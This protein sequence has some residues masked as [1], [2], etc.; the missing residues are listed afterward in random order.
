MSLAVSRIE[1]GACEWSRIDALSPKG[2][3]VPPSGFSLPPKD[4]PA[5][6]LRRCRR[7][8]SGKCFFFSRKAA[9]WQHLGVPRCPGSTKPSDWTP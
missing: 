1:E 5:E 3:P 9:V 2:P 8:L 7:T 4:Q 6:Y